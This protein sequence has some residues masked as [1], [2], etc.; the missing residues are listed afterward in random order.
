MNHKT[1]AMAALAVFA[2][3]AR[4]ATQGTTDAN[5]QTALRPPELNAYSSG[6]PYDQVRQGWHFFDDPEPEVPQ[7]PAEVSKNQIPQPSQ[8]GADR[9]DLRRFDAM[10]KQLED[11]RKIAVL[12]PTD[13]N[14]R[15]Y[16]EM[17]TRVYRMAGRFSDVSQRVAWSTPEL[18][19]SLQGR[20]INA[21]AIDVFDKVLV[22]QR[23]DSI[24]ALAK[25]H[26]LFFFFRSDCPYCHA[27]SP[28]L[29]AFEGRS[30]I[31]VVPVSLDGGG[32]PVYPEPRRDNGIATT[33]QVTQVPALY[34]AEP[35]TGKITPIGFGILSESQLLERIATVSAPGAEGTL[36]SATKRVR[37]Q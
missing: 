30:G 34:L 7:E 3:L 26:V 19:M 33:L 27:F 4:A 37:L 20:P 9:A 23:H 36:P 24:V 21:R 35:S 13:Q 2:S 22:K 1:V 29:R 14:V 10:Q 16:M 12:N 32:L 5:A 6:A 31:K 28:T 18:D 11:Y 8:Q 17:E 25:T 15:R